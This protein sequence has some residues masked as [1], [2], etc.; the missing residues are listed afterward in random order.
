VH[1]IPPYS[2]SCLFLCPPRSHWYQLPRQDLFCLPVLCFDSN[3]FC[4]QNQLQLL[5]SQ[6]QGEV[7]HS[8]TAIKPVTPRS[9][10]LTPH[11]LPDYLLDSLSH[12]SAPPSRLLVPRCIV[13]S[14]TN[15][16]T[17]Y[18]KEEYPNSYSLW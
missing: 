8:R 2:L 1:N 5:E 18:P 3:F 4:A 10:M 11:Y 17:L 6:N 9:V 12:A 15:A 7:C 16:L 13:H 14:T